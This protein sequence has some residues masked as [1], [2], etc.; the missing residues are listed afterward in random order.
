MSALS[1]SSE[2]PSEYL[3]DNSW[4]HARIRLAI[5]ES[6][7]GPN[8]INH[9]ERLGVAN[10]WHCLEVGGGDGSIT[11]WLCRRV[12]TSGRVVSTDLDTSFLEKLEFPNL[13]VWRHN[14]VDD[15]L[16]RGAFDL[17]HV[18]YVLMHLRERGR[19]LHQLVAALKP[20]GWLLAEEADAMSFVADPRNGE[21][22]CSHFARVGAAL[23]AVG[24]GL[25]LCYGRRLYAD[26]CSEGLIEVD[27]AGRTTMARGGSPLAQFWRITYTQVRDA[28]LATGRLRS[29]ELDACIALL[30]DPD[31]V[32]TSMTSM[33][34]CGRRPPK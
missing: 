18:R 24:G 32:F 26:V 3:L 9:L 28:M 21:A 5:L 15:E 19:A 34:V 23:Q 20:G 14:V 31:F 22:A 6:W 11:E 27:A 4:I 16:E 30:D 1:I 25:D 13:D 33:A 10:S 2:S 17:V 7:A 8:T 12:G 29:D